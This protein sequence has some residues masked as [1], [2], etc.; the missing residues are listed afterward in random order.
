MFGVMSDR[1]WITIVGLGEDGPD[2]LPPASLAALKSADVVMGAKRHLT[3]LPEVAAAR[4]EWPVPFA[5]GI[6]VLKGMRGQSVVV[7]ASGDPFWF[8]AGSVIAREFKPGEWVALPAP[9]CFALAAS[10]MGWALEHTVCL[11]LHAQDFSLVRP[12]L[13]ANLRVLITVRDGPAV[14]QFAD[15]LAAVGF[16]DSKLTVLQALGGPREAAEVL[17]AGAVT[18]TTFTHPVCIAV[19]PAGEGDELPLSSGLPDRLFA[20]DGVMTKRAVRAVTLSSLAPKRGEVLWDIGGGSGTIGIEWM[21]AHSSCRAIAI[22]PRADRVA[23]IRENAKA[24]GTPQLDVLHGSAP[25][26]LAELPAPDAVF[27]GGGLSA[28]ML[29]TLRAM[30]PAG[31]RIVANAV[32]LEAEAL[33]IEAQ[34]THGGELIQLSVSEADALGDKTGWKPA[35]PIVQWAGS[36]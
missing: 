19:E 35:R 10:R 4:V 36:L 18:E 9:S 5:D 32:T 6:D 2:G 8:G 12:Y 23:L 20:S 3:L 30:L 13:G 11:G 17:I 22:E 25:D 1:P 33:L 28:D 34:K 31:V 14:G 16:A 29:A 15:Y 21:L 24:L 7:L 27:I 26:C